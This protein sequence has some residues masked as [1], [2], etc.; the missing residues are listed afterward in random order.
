[1]NIIAANYLI[2]SATYKQCPPPDKA[3]YAFIGRSNVGKSSLINMITG[4]T[5]LA[6]TSASPGKTQLIN[7]FEILTS[8][9]KKWFIVDLPGYGYA[10]VSQKARRNWENMIESYIRKRENLRCLFV[11]IDSRHEPQAIDLSFINKLGEWNIPFAIVFTKTDKNKPGATI[12]NVDAFLDKL[13]ETWEAPPLFFL[14]SAI[15]ATGRKE[16]LGYVRELNSSFSKS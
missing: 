15:K 1:M 3:E 11:L 12:R 9:K 2:S 10:S 8:D 6:K 4:R 14:T 13:K 16:I 5:G 7:H